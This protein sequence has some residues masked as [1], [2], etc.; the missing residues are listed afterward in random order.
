MA[1][2]RSSFEHKTVE[3]SVRIPI[4]SPFCEFDFD[5]S[6]I[7]AEM[8]VYLIAVDLLVVLNCDSWG[9]WLK[10]KVRNLDL[11]TGIV[12]NLIFFIFYF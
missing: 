10:K 7:L 6:G 4:S 3:I 11:E 9:F 5:L 2:F 12:K 8:S 1:G